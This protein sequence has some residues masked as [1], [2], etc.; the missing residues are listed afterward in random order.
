MC[1]LD[2]QTLMNLYIQL[3]LKLQLFST[4]NHKNLSSYCYLLDSIIWE[5]I[6]IC[7]GTNWNLSW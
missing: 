7:F 2:I 3:G 4:D 6:V 1:H 5:V